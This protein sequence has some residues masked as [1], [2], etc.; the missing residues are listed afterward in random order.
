MIHVFPMLTSKDHIN[1]TIL[2]GVCKSLEMFILTYRL[3]AITTKEGKPS[4]VQKGTDLMLSQAGIKSMKVQEGSTPKNTDK[5]SKYDK[6]DDSKSGFKPSSKGS[7]KIEFPKGNAESLTIQPTWVNVTTPKGGTQIVGVKVIPFSIDDVG[8]IDLMSKD[9]KRAGSDLFFRKY[10]RAIAAVAYKLWYKSL[11]K[12]LQFA[13]LGLAGGRP[14]ISGDPKTDIVLRQTEFKDNVF[15]MLNKMDFDEGMF[16][17]VGGMK[18]LYSLGWNSVLFADDQ[19]TRAVYCMKEFGGICTGV[20]YNFLYSSVSQT[21]SKVYED[22]TDIKK[23]SGSIFRTK[24]DPRKLFGESIAASK[25]AKYGSPVVESQEVINESL[26]TESIFDFK[27][28]L[29]S[30]NITNIMRALNKAPIKDSEVK[31]HEAAFKKE[32]PDYD[33]S[34]KFSKQVINNSLPELPKDVNDSMAKI[35]AAKSTNGKDTMKETRKNL[36][37]VVG[38]IQKRKDKEDKV[39]K[40]SVIAILFIIVAFAAVALTALFGPKLFSKAKDTN[41]FNKTSIIIS[42]LKKTIP[43]FIKNETQIGDK[44][45]GAVKTGKDLAKG[46]N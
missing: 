19:N 2:P 44:I 14:T 12:V 39:R 40:E 8:L 38:D 30:K 9:I 35:I 13:S 25:K 21:A 28:A 17:S 20:P 7:T 45:Y 37:K 18:K 33:K 32:N 3:D 1:P 26:L 23:T 46:K 43:I 6:R 42:N 16:E 31:K 4:I 11:D 10:E 36:K 41:S 15:V 5:G 34:Y 27:N 22:L 29:K 24:I